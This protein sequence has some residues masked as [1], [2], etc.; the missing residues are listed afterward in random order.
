M[1]QK[2]E[3]ND[4]NARWDSA[5]SAFIV[6]NLAWM[7]ALWILNIHTSNRISKW[8]WNSGLTNY[9]I[10]L[11]GLATLAACVFAATRRRHAQFVAL[12]VVAVLWG[13]AGGIFYLASWGWN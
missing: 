3:N 4:D 1:E 12:V 5:L 13:A 9:S 10:V 11:C 2:S 6:V 8:V 7:A